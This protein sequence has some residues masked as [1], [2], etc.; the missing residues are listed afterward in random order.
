MWKLIWLCS[1]VEKINFLRARTIIIG[2]GVIKIEIWAENARNHT[3]R[4]VEQATTTRNCAT[5]STSSTHFTSN[6]HFVR[7]WNFKNILRSDVNQVTSEVYFVAT[8]AAAESVVEFHKTDIKSLRCVLIDIQ[9]S[10]IKWS[11]DFKLSARNEERI[12]KN[13][14]ERTLFIN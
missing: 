3:F 4:S 14:Q 13:F 7:V 8:V 9:R 11:N 5:I 10:I 12:K 1:K 2:S 6:L